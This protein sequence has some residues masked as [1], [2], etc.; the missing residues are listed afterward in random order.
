MEMTN[1]QKGVIGETVVALEL[2]ERGWDVIN[3]NN[4]YRNYRNA[5]LVCMNANNGKSTMIQVKTGTTHN[6]LTGFTSELDGTIPDIENSVIGPWVFVY[7]PDD[8]LSNMDFYILTKEEVKELIT[9][10][11]KWYVS[12]WNRELKSKPMVGVEV[13][14]LKGNNNPGKSTPK[15]TYPEYNNP[16]GHNSKDMW[17]KI[18]SLLL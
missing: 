7:M 5:D 13:D 10:S 18:E 1:K 17:E 15:Y 6:I 2:M 11:N 8:K 3:I 14:W 16:L 9:S 4:T 12:E